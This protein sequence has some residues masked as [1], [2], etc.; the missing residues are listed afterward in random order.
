MQICKLVEVKKKR[1]VAKDRYNALNFVLNL[2]IAIPV[3]DMPKIINEIFEG[4]FSS[5]SIKTKIKTS[6]KALTKNS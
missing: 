2:K 6:P 4:L 1:S 5:K 3:S